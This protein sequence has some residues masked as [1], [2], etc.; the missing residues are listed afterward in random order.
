[1]LLAWRV[2]PTHLAYE[3]EQVEGSNEEDGHPRAE[4]AV[5]HLRLD[6]GEQAERDEVGEPDRQHVWPHVSRHL[7]PAAAPD[8]HEN[9]AGITS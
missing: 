2:P 6:A 8:W 7:P 5:D 1:M 4:S 9:T 3:V